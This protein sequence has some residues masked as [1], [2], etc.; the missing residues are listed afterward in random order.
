M[1]KSFRRHNTKVT[2][3]L[4]APISMADGESQIV[5]NDSVNLRD[6]FTSRFHQKGR[7]VLLRQ[8]SEI[9]CKCAEGLWHIFPALS[10]SITPTK[11]PNKSECECLRVSFVQRGLNFFENIRQ[12]F[13]Q[14]RAPFFTAH[15][16][17][18]RVL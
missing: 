3:R 12:T 11:I 6:I 13:R 5:R 18:F 10:S 17:P 7:T 15:V 14:E 8:K 9:C 1:E 2:K 4:N 16:S